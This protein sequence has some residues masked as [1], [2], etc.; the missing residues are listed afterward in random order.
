MK[1]AKEWCESKCHN[2]LGYFEF[3]SHDIKEI[4]Q[5]AGWKTTEPPKDGSTI[6]AI[7]RVI[8]TEDICTSV[9]AFLGEI[10]WLKDKSGYTGWHFRETGM[11][12]ARALDD[13]VMIDLWIETPR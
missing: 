13:K 2:R 5:D 7:G 3:Q 11:T 1:T 8:I 12:I 10:S 9:D 6:V 4:Q